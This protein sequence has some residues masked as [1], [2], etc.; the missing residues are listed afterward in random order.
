MGGKIKL[1]YGETTG[2]YQPVRAEPADASIAANIEAMLYNVLPLIEMAEVEREALEILTPFIA[3]DLSDALRSENMADLAP[4]LPLDL[5]ELSDDAPTAAHDAARVLLWLWAAQWLAR[6]G[7]ASA[8]C[9]AMHAGRMYERMTVRQFE[10]D[11]LTGGKV[12]R[13]QSDGH[14]A[15]HGTQAE[16]ERRWREYAECF[17]GHCR[18]GLKATAAYRRAAKEFNVSEKTIRRAVSKLRPK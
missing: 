11:A 9:Y 6:K 5:F 13:G 15:T 12:R 17:H 3:P 4:D 16:K 2:I 10:P 18:G 1:V 7:E 14:A 8:I